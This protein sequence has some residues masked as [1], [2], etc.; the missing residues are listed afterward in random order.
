MNI[1]FSSDGRTFLADVSEQ[2]T[3]SLDIIPSNTFN[4]HIGAV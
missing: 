4:G 3:L 1:A 2:A